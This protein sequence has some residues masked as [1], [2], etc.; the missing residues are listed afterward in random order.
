MLA[1]ETPAHLW[2][3]CGSAMHAARLRPVAVRDSE[4]RVVRDSFS[5]S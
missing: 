2:D 4:T 1:P 5:Y 3:L